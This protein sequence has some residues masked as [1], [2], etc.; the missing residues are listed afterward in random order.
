VIDADVRSAFPASFLLLGGPD[1]LS[2]ASIRVQ[3]DPTLLLAVAEQAAAGDFEPLFDRSTYARIGLGLCEVMPG[4]EPWPIELSDSGAPRFGV[5]PTRS[6]VPLPFAW[7]DFV[8]AA[9]LSHRLPG[10]MSFTGLAPRGSGPVASAQ[11]IA[12][13]VQR[14]G[15]ARDRLR[16]GIGSTDDFRTKVQ[17]HPVV[18]SG[19]WGIFARADQHRRSGGRGRHS[20]LVEEVAEWTWPPLAVSVPALPRLWMGMVQRWVADQGGICISWDTDGVTIL[21]STEGGTHKLRDGRVVRVLPHAEIESFLA[22]FDALDP[23]GD[24]RPFWDVER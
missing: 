14:R 7:G 10:R 13:E 4:G 20:V 24:G 15:A 6:R 8:N 1:V 9:V 3:H 22:R 11:W 18:N 12:A 16:N 19:A 2:A 5:W 17:L 23:F 21:S